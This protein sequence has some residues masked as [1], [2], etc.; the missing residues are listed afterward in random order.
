MKEFF[1]TKMI[2]FGITTVF[3]AGGG[4]MSLG[5]LGDRVT[6]LEDKQDIVGGDIRTMMKNQAKMC[7]AL[8]VDCQ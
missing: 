1:D 7:H 4:W 8:K 3:L 5:S 6:K 2:I